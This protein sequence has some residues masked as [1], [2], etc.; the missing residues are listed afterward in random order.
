MSAR[1]LIAA[2]IFEHNMN[3]EAVEAM[4]VSRLIQYAKLASELSAYRQR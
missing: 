4:P 3:P 1:R 2:M